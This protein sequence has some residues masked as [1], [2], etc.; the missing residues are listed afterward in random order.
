MPATLNQ[1]T[2]ALPVFGESKSPDP[3]KIETVPSRQ[4]IDDRPRFRLVHVQSG[5]AIGGQFLLHEAELI[6]QI[7]AHWDWT[8]DDNRQPACRL[9][10]LHLLEQICCKPQHLQGGEAA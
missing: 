7:T 2:L 10:L 4:S 6:Q 8:L 9:Q 5:L 3:L 1:L